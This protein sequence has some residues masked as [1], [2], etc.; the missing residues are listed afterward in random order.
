ML[1]FLF[2]L[3]VET[4]ENLTFDDFAFGIWTGEKMLKKRVYDLAKTW[5]KLMPQIDI[6]S[7]YINDKDALEILNTSNHLNITFHSIPTFAHHLFGT[8]FDNV[9]NHAQSRHLIAFHDLYQRYPNKK[10]YFL[11]DDDTF[12]LPDGIIST[13]KNYSYNERQ[14]IGHLFGNFPFLSKFFQSGKKVYDFAQGGAGFFV[15]K[16][17]MDYVA[18][19]IIDCS[20]FY[21]SYNFVSDT[22]ISAC[23]DFL[24][25]INNITRDESPYVNL[26]YLI[27]GDK[28][29][30]SNL[31]NE[32][33]QR[34][35]S[36]H[37][38]VPP[39]TEIMWNATFSRWN[40]KNGTEML[41]EWTHV[42]TSKFY[43]E[44]GRR[45][46]FMEFI[47]GYQLCSNLH[48]ER[49]MSVSQLEPIFENDEE[50]PKSYVQKYEGNITMKYLCD[51][52]IEFG[53]FVFDSFLPIEEQGSTYRV[54][55]ENPR[56]YINNF[57][58]GSPYV[59]IHQDQSD[60]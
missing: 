23:I 42:A 8:S 50:I 59:H 45:N 16:A 24:D 57:P 36:Y 47:W 29:E 52:T 10:W 19:H 40:A 37:H 55:C 30:E 22:R 3:S 4:D 48:M 13:L 38:I 17:M 33:T 60:L 25:V 1:N 46:N 49:F 18:P 44:V 53:E 11:G 20:S 43:T 27:H 7:D 6:Y 15:S 2:S 41:V 5:I 35:I 56:T 31:K 39:Y 51:D 21:E 58:N 26:D 28:P 14:I 34:P 32:Y 54:R 12:L 9:W